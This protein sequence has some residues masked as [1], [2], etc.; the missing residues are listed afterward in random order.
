MERPKN[1]KLD[2]KDLKT[3]S[4]YNNGNLAIID[5]LTNFDIKEA[6]ELNAYIIGLCLEGN[7]SV[8]ING[9]SHIVHTNNLFTAPPNVILDEGWLSED[10]K[11]RCICIAT[12][13]IKK[14]L[15]IITN[16]WDIKILFEKKPVSMLSEKEV[17][18]FCLYYDLLHS[19]LEEISQKKYANEIIDAL[20]VAFIYEFKE[21]IDKSFTIKPYQYSA[22]ENLFNAFIELISSL[23]PKP[24]TVSYYANR[25][26]ISPKYFSMICKEI[27][28]APASKIIDR[29]V[30]KDIEFLLKNTQFSI[31]EIA[32]E[33]DFPNLS[34]FGKYTKKHFGISPKALRKHYTHDRQ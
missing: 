29:F 19:R 34:F 3:N 2:D 22:G 8:R 4:V 17:S 26:C 16:Y 32:M 7:A 15:P 1:K 23:K 5:N 20:M 18:T 25:L 10:F 11:C 31:K 28:G 6:S 24:R 33:L 30:L 27:G 14:I 13:Y 12:E 21:T 9:V